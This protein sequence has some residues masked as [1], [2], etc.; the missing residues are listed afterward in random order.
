MGIPIL[1]VR[2]DQGNII[3]IPAI[4][5]RDGVDGK[6]GKDG[7]DGAAGPNLINQN[8]LTPMAGSTDGLGRQCKNCGIWD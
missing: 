2:D 5:G 3:P 6:D 4:Q 8:T 7:K 1:S